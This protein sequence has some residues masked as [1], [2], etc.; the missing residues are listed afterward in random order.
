MSGSVCLQAELKPHF[1]HLTYF[2]L[3]YI[4]AGYARKRG[5]FL[6]EGTKMKHLIYKLHTHTSAAAVGVTPFY[7]VG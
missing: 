6:L 3:T 2:L 1:K 4:P 5:G 7:G